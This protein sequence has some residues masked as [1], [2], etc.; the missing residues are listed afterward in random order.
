MARQYFKR[1]SVAAFVVYDGGCCAARSGSTWPARD[2]SHRLQDYHG[3]G[4]LL[5]G[6]PGKA[7]RAVQS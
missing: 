5:G 3:F 6:L 1:W 4:D 2:P 7:N